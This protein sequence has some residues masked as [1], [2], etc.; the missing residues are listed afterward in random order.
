[1]EGGGWR[2]HRQGDSSLHLPYKSM[3]ISFIKDRQLSLKAHRWHCLFGG[4]SIMKYI[5][6]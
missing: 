3:L 6:R 4:H 2:G 1:M 5:N